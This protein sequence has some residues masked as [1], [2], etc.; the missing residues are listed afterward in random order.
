MH[1]RWW[2]IAPLQQ[3]QKLAGLRCHDTGA[4]Q[5]HQN[6][7]LVLRNSLAKPDGHIEERGGERADTSGARINGCCGVGG[8]GSAGVPG[9]GTRTQTIEQHA[10]TLWNAYQEARRGHDAIPVART[11]RRKPPSRRQ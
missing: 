9:T 4:T 11:Q 7:G 2:Q 8:A 6:A 3:P 5:T 10:H 1:I